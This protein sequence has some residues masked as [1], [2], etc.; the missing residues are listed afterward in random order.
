[1]RCLQ[2]PPLQP[3]RLY[4]NYVRKFSY[5]RNPYI[6]YVKRE[7]PPSPLPV[8]PPNLTSKGPAFYIMVINPSTGEV[9]RT[10]IYAFVNGHNRV[11]TDP[12]F[13]TSDSRIPIAF[14]HA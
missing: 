11:I 3:I 6:N 1:M 13:L 4:G 12:D 7:F 2:I 9:T 14:E 5:P 10:D 8:P